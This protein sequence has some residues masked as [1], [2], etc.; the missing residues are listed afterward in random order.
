[1]V[2]ILYIHGYRANRSLMSLQTAR[3]KRRLPNCNHYII[4]GKHVAQGLPEDPMVRKHYPP[5]HFEHCQFNYL[6]N[7]GATYTGIEESIEYLKEIAKEKEIDGIVAFSQGTYISSILASQIPLKFFVSVCGMR[8]VDPK[9]EVNFDV[10][11]Y[12]IV[13]KEDQWRERG[14]EFSKL[15]PDS[16]LVEHKGG[17]H[18]PR[19][20]CIY[21]QLVEWIDSQVVV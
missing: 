5:P 6:P 18:F 11:S 21:D 8:C 1:M 16:Q 10:P 9:Y 2:N 19:E 13:G 15:Y 4:D 12:H 14:V 17:H 3:L 20:D 7:G